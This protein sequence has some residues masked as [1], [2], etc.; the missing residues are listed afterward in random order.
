MSAASGL[1]YVLHVFELAGR[2]IYRKKTKA[3]G[4]EFA[5]VKALKVHVGAG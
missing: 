5:A 1:F 2:G 3:L 4:R